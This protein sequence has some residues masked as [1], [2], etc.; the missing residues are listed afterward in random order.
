M[1]VLHQRGHHVSLVARLRTDEETQLSALMHLCDHIYT[2]PH[3][4]DLP[5]A[6]PLALWRSYWALRQKTRLAL[7][8]VQPDALLVEMMPTAIAILG[9]EGKHATL[10][11]HDVDWFLF[12]QR[13]AETRGWRRVGARL[14]AWALRQVEPWVMRRYALV[15]TVSYGDARLLAPL[16]LPLITLPLEP[17]AKPEQGRD[18]SQPS[19]PAVLF[20]GAMDRAYNQEGVLW[21]MARV[22]PRVRSAVPEATFYVVGN[23]PPPELM[24]LNGQD[25]VRVTGF[26]HDLAAWYARATVFVAPMRV[27]GGMLQKVLDALALGV[28]TVAT[29]VSNHGIQATPGE[30]LLLADDAAAFAEA[31]I[32]LLRD[33]Q[34]AQ[35]LGE[36]ARHF[37]AQRFNLE[38]AVAAWESRMGGMS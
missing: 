14:V 24:A 8:E 7:R 10:R 26:V 20:V 23:A 28:P 38:Q 6:R 27:A 21:F 35:A 34:R 17:G 4:K 13:A 11:V 18:T 22:W 15:S 19:T 29:S 37:V 36:A 5:D 31:V 12:E 30:H 2:V 9:L 33:P 25:G 16:K 1:Q 32:T 3:H